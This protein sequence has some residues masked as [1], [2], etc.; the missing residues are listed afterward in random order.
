M[1][2]TKTYLNRMLERMRV[3]VPEDLEKELLDQYGEYAEDD[4]G[5]LHDYTEQD[6]Y[7]QVRKIIYEYESSKKPASISF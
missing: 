1:L 5:H 4:E 7:E 6:I 2:L 3:S